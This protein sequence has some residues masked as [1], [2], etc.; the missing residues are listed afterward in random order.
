M[1]RSINPMSVFPDAPGLGWFGFAPERLI[2]LMSLRPAIPRRVALL[3]CSLPLH[4]AIAMV[5]QAAGKRQPPLGRGWGIFSW[6]KGEIS[7]GVDRLA[8]AVQ[9]TRPGLRRQ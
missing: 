8:L 7:F 6:R 1:S 9:L 5:N 4:R 3:H 2:V